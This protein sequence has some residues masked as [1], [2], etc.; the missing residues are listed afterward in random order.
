M[1]RAM[2]RLPALLR[3]FFLTALLMGAAAPSLA[4]P[5]KS[6]RAAVAKNRVVFQISEDDT[7]KW[8]SVLGNIHNIQYDLAKEGV[9]VTLVAIGPGLGMLLADSLVANRVQDAMAD[10]VRFVA[11]GNSMEAQHIEKGDLVAGT[12]TVKAGYVEVMRLQQQGWVYLR[13]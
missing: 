1:L 12:H 6:A 3:I 9:A 8:N 2:I 11:C 5:A 7:R 4:E 13:P 10:G